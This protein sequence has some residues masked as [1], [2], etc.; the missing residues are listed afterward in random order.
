MIRTSAQKYCRVRE[1]VGR[2]DMLNHAQNITNAFS[3][4]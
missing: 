2:C 3:P 1:D 4:D